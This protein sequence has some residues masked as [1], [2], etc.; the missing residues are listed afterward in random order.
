MAIFLPNGKFIINKNKLYTMFGDSIKEIPNIDNSSIFQINTGT[1]T[2]KQ[3]KRVVNNSNYVTITMSTFPT[4]NINNVVMYWYGVLSVNASVT[5]TYNSTMY[6]S[7]ED[8]AFQDD[9][10]GTNIIVVTFPSDTYTQG[11][12]T[13]TNSI[14]N[15][16]GVLQTHNLSSISVSTLYPKIKLTSYGS[17]TH[18]FNNCNITIQYKY[19]ALSIIA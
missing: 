19:Y 5:R 18:I 14:T 10:T 3:T 1:I 17:W 8:Y 7:S 9:K 12:H 4:K 11:Q 15:D 6:V 2:S 13:K 16:M